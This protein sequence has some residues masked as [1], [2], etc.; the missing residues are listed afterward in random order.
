MS[1]PHRLLA[2][3]AL[4]R[5]LPGIRT[6]ASLLIAL[7]ILATVS[8]LSRLSTYAQTIEP[9]QTAE[10]ETRSA[11]RDS[12]RRFESSESATMATPLAAKPGALGFTVLN[13]YVVIKRPPLAPLAAGVSDLLPNYYRFDAHAAFLQRRA[14]TI[15]NPL[16]LAAGSFDLAFVLVFLVPIL[17]IALSYDV[18]S[19]E[20]ELGVLALVGAQGVSIRRF[21][22]A[23]LLIRGLMIVTAIIGVNVIAMAVIG[24]FS[25]AP[26]LISAA[27]WTLVA[28]FY[29]LLWFGLAALTNAAGFNSATNGV[30]L[31]NL[32]LLLVIVLPAV[33][34][35]IATNV[36]PAPSRVDLT[37]E[38]REASTEAEER[39]AEAREQY[40]FDHPD[41][42]AG[43]VD[44]E[45]F[46]R[47]V[48]RGEDDIA[49]SIEPWLRRFE[50]QAQ[51]QGEVVAW[52]K[53][54][55]PAL[56]AD[57]SFATLAGTDRNYH[58]QFKV[59]AF[60][61]HTDWRKFFV[62]RLENDIG[63]TGDGWSQLPA[64]NWSP[65]HAGKQARRVLVPAAVLGIMAVLLL[66]MALIKFR[67]YSP[68]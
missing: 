53:Y 16:R 23:K 32:W 45:I 64:F 4:L 51:R 58:A 43:D 2:E 10:Q 6:L 65:P 25:E 5:H 24:T 11:L 54:F 22:A 47:D 61:Y 44:Q 28:V 38:L 1:R 66:C 50:E 29:G 67:R 62:S 57:Q 68:V 49:Q 27:S 7:A 18:M 35:M 36:Y 56:L 42:A 40:F 13:E 41:L 46:Y 63:M 26:M 59:A 21:I 33:I 34:N 14:G 30:I 37:T 60:N 12:M 17:V 9:L 3:V 20:K 55:S 19:R 8:G 48:A 39:A 15:D 52:M 31:A